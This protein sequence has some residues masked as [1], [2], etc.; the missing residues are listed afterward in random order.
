MFNNNF[1]VMDLRL[2][3]EPERSDRADV[4]KVNCALFQG[5]KEDN[6]TPIWITLQAW[7]YQ[8]RV[9]GGLH[10]NQQVT[11]GGSL[12]QDNWED[13]DG[14]EKSRLVLTAEWISEKL[15]A[16]SGQQNNQQPIG[17]QDGYNPNS[18]HGGYQNQG[19]NQGQEGGEYQQNQGS[20]Q[21]GYQ[22][23]G[24]QQG[25]NQGYQSNGQNQQNGGYQNQGGNQNAQPQDDIPFS[26]HMI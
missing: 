14:N 19:G 12:K 22:N 8:A 25:E 16:D 9:L 26:P 7:K 20:G 21:G 6:I 2:V 4:V 23:Q 24:Q 3:A 5:K 11:V 18:G 17:D 15:W 1:S 13:Q 10:K